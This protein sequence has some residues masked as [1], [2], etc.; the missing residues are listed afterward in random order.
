MA[1]EDVLDQMVENSGRLECVNW[2]HVGQWPPLAGSQAPS[3]AQAAW[4]FSNIQ[5]A[6]SNGGKR[7][8]SGL[9]FLNEYTEHREFPDHSHCTIGSFRES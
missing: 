7:V 3:E 1:L 4:A 2:W 5:P 8:T 9:Q 6:V